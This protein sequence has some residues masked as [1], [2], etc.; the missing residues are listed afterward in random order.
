MATINGHFD[1]AKL[2]LDRGADPNRAA[3]NGVAPLYARSTSSGR[4]GPADPQP[5][6]HWTRSCRTWT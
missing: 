5:R 1:L 6:A 4:R 2:L 3:I